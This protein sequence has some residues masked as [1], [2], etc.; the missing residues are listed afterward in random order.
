MGRTQVEGDVV[1]SRFRLLKLAG[2]GGFG[3]VY[4]ALDLHTNQ[5]VALKLMADVEDAAR[6][7]R[8]AAIL[9]TIHHP[10][11]AGH[12]AHGLTARGA[13]YLA[14]EWLEGVDLGQHLG[15]GALPFA[16]ALTV[17]LH[18]AEGLAAAHALG[19][20]HRD[21]KPANLFLVGGRPDSV[22]LIDFGIARASSTAA[23]LTW[24]GALLGTPQY[25]SPEQ[26]MGER[27]LGPS[28]D[29]FSL[30]SVLFECLTG[31]PAFEGASA[32]AVLGKIL[33]GVL[34]RLDEHRAAIPAMVEALLA[35]MLAYEPCDRLRDGGAVAVAV[36]SMRAGASLPSELRTAAPLGRG[37]R[38]PPERLGVPL[39]L[40]DAPLLG[41]AR[42]LALVHGAVRSAVQDPG[43]QLVL[44]TGE[45]GAGKSRLIAH[46]LRDLA[47]RTD[48]PRVLRAQADAPTSASPFALVGEIVAARLRTETTLDPKKLLGALLQQGLDRVDSDWA[49]ALAALGS[50]EFAS[51]SAPAR[52]DPQIVADAYRHAWLSLIEST[53]R[54]RPLAL[55]LE[56]LHFADP[57][58]IAL[59]DAALEACAELPLAVIATLR[60]SDG[61]AALR[62]LERRAPEVV[63]LRPLRRNV[64]LDLVR[65]YLP[66]AEDDVAGRIVELAEGNPL[67]VAELARLGTSTGAGGSLI[68]AIEARLARLPADVQRTLRAASTFGRSFP[69]RGVL[70][71][72][73]GAASRERVAEGLELARRER[74]VDV[75]IEQPDG[76]TFHHVLVRDAAY[77]SFEDDDRKTAHDGA[78][79]YLLARPG[80]DPSL[81]AWHLERGHEAELAADWY[82]KAARA[83]LEGQDLARAVDLADRAAR[84]DAVA[85][86]RARLLLIRAEASFQR[87]EVAAGSAAAREAMELSSPGSVG[88]VRAAGQLITALGQSGTNDPLIVLAERLRDQAPHPEAR[89]HWVIAM[90]RATTQ[91]QA[92]G[93]SSLAQGCFDAATSVAADGPLVRAWQA[94]VRATFAWKLRDFGLVIAE[95]SEAARLFAL[96]GDARQAC[97]MRIQL[98]SLLS[99]AGNFDGAKDELAIGEALARRTGASYFMGWAAYTRGKILAQTS[100]PA[101]ARTH[102]ESVRRQIASSPRIVAGTH[103]YSAIAAFRAQDASWAEMEA[104]AALAAHTAPA[105]QAA[106]Q[107]SLARALV[108][109][110]RLEEAAEASRRSIELLRELGSMDEHESLVHLAAMEVAN[111]GGSRDEAREAA[112][113]ALRH[114]TTISDKLEN[115]VARETFL[116]G[117]EVHDR[118]LRLAHA[119]GVQITAA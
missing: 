74:F 104:R 9:E 94:R 75:D 89:S 32:G 66:D 83:A 40:M 105:V 10:R 43:A 115:A 57:A 118:I 88:W 90:C 62:A 101:A 55:V 72:L 25:M 47:E 34:P 71:L 77:A 60:P 7:Q 108:M 63:E 1:D 11:V 64:A 36:A 26:A 103:V 24:T 21:V 48:A 102:L 12:V 56:D 13:P 81:V 20:V 78:A 69:M 82:E 73:G 2:Q 70:S 91:L 106:A 80:S 50:A 99:F 76:F 23:T 6:F 4:R 46:V 92:I 84:I 16:D 41:R 54:E 111:A 110:E 58:S 52:D 68:G 49:V 37:R 39:E 59:V 19:I 51:A 29:V 53:A 93:Q 42:E 18:A 119:L 65:H 27:D 15:C 67:R 114:L 98:G 8:E 96:G 22:R 38:D 5:S 79:R 35:R 31:K 116:H 97:L 3:A 44:V 17:C 107:A 109:Q 87:G 33:R 112:R 117:I 30:G 86:R 14:M 95:H 113:S 85:E 45:A 28:S 61:Q 100:E